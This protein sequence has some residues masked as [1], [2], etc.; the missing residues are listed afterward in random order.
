LSPAHPLADLLALADDLKRLPRRA[1]GGAISVDCN[2]CTTM[3][4]AASIDEY[5]GRSTAMT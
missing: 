4:Q 5:C 2:A 1:S 3:G